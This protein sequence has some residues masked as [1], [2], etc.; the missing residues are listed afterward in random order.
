[1]AETLRRRS[2]SEQAAWHEGYE[3]GLKMGAGSEPPVP[4]ETWDETQARRQRN[5]DGPP[6]S[7]TARR[8]DL[9]PLL[10]GDLRA[11]LARSESEAVHAH[12]VP[13]VGTLWW[14]ASGKIVG[15]PFGWLRR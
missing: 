8:R 1:M 13:G 3:Y 2:P 12:E 4:G 15:G 14:D 11:A 10:T 9:A 6:R 5:L 7:S